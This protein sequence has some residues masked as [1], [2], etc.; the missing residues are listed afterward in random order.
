MKT[1]KVSFVVALM[2]GIP[3]LCV[4]AI[5]HSAYNQGRADQQAADA[6]KVQVIEKECP[7]ETWVPLYPLDTTPPAHWSLNVQAYWFGKYDPKATPLE[8]HFK[9]FPD[10]SR[11]F[12]FTTIEVHYPH[13]NSHK[14]PS[15]GL[16]EY[17]HY[18]KSD[19][20]NMHSN[21]GDVPMPSVMN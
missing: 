18:G 3:W 20:M 8:G 21:I 13:P 2:I 14:Q 11:P 10:P 7:T 5:N 4:W 17:G 15:K 12:C 1:L 16:N 6:A 19:H 9:C